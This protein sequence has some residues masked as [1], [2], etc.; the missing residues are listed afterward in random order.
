MKAQEIN[1]ELDHARD[2]GPVKDIVIPPCPEL[3]AQLQAELSQTDPDPNVV[4]AIA[5]SDVAMAAALIRIA[6]SSLYAR[7]QPVASGGQAVSMLGV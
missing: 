7:R 5:G 1:R 4:A 3:L 6:N 2:A